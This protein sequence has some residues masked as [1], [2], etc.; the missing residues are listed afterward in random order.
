MFKSDIQ[1]RDMTD[2][3]HLTLWWIIFLKF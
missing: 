1:E 3:R 2:L